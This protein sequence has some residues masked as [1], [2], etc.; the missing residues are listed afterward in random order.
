MSGLDPV[1]AA[2]VVI[3]EAGTQYSATLREPDHLYAL[4][5]EVP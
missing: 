1:R 2:T 4:S 3:R 5:S